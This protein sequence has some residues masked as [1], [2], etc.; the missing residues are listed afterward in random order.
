MQLWR[1]LIIELL[2]LTVEDIDCSDEEIWWVGHVRDYGHILDTSWQ[3]YVANVAT[4]VGSLTLSRTARLHWY[5]ASPDRDHWTVDTSW[6][7]Y[8]EAIPVRSLTLMEY[9]LHQPVSPGGVTPEVG[10]DGWNLPV[11]DDQPARNSRC[12]AGQRSTQAGLAG[13]NF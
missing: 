3:C 6:Q 8:V 1:W 5:P 9:W 4:L 11:G 13:R 2:M 10:R 7:C 12:D